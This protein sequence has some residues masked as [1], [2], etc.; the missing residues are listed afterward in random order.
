MRKGPVGPAESSGRPD[1]EV[2]VPRRRLEVAVG[3]RQRDLAT[4]D[5]VLRSASSFSLVVELRIPIE[6]REELDDTSLFV[7]CH[8]L[9]QRTGD[10]RGLGAFTA[11]SEGVCEQSRVDIQVRRHV[12][13]L[14]REAAPDQRE[15]EEVAG[16]ASCE[17]ERALRSLVRSM[18]RGHGSTHLPH[19]PC[20]RRLKQ[21]SRCSI[22]V[23]ATRMCLRPQRSITTA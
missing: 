5:H 7:T 6:G 18:L 17:G 16:P 1:G 20:R 14:A 9:A 22:H 4:V 3:P 23:V 11:H 19:D 12:Q 13:M 2:D 8:E 21:R 15:T 10:S